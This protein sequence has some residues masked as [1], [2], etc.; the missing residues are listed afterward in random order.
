MTAL[1]EITDEYMQ[2]MLGSSRPYTA[3]LLRLTEKA[4]EPEA[5]R[6]IWEHGRRNLALR[7]EGKMPIICPATDDSDWAGIGIFDA[8]PQEVDRIMADD[9]G[10]TAGVF[11]YELHPVFGFPGASLP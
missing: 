8:T 1:A 7:A 11:T 5:E 9:P 6:V 2:Q 3:M 10:V 4:A